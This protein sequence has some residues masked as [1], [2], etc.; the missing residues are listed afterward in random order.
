MAT[1]DAWALYVAQKLLYSIE[2]L[3]DSVNG[4]RAAP[5]IVHAS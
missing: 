5:R 2:P 1:R 4:G 3:E